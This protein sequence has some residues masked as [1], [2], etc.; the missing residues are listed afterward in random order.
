[1]TGGAAVQSSMRS[2][3]VVVLG[4]RVELPLELLDGDGGGSGLKP[5]LQGLV[6]P[7][8]L[9]LGL[10]VAGRSVL[11]ADAEQRE[12]VLKRVASATEPGGIDPAVIGEG[13]GRRPVTL[14]ALKERAHDRVAGDWLVRGAPQ[15]IPGV[16]IQ[17]VQDLHVSTVSQ[18]PVQAGPVPGA[19]LVDRLLPSPRRGG[20][21]GGVRE[22]YP[23]QPS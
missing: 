11:L 15:Q 12:E 16:V 20:A 3:F 21:G 22:T 5:A 1:M 17:P 6:E 2:V 14:Q 13:A 9:A 19:T 10:G 8:D 7:L 18:P 4:E 23:P